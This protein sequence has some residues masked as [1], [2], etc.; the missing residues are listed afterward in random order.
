MQWCAAE[1]AGEE[2]PVIKDLEAKKI[3]D[4]GG[5]EFEYI[6]EGLT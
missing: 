1:E 5:F 4:N 2:C 3:H 6:E